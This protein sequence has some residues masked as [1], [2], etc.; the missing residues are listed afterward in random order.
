MTGTT[1][2]LGDCADP[3][4]QEVPRTPVNGR[5]RDPFQVGVDALRD[6]LLGVTVPIRR[7][8]LSTDDM[9][10]EQWDKDACQDEPTTEGGDLVNIPVL[11]RVSTDDLRR[12]FRATGCDLKEAAVRI[13]ESAAWRGVTFP[14][15]TR[16]CRV[17]LQSG[18]FFQQ[19]RDVDG[20]PVF[21]FQNMLMGPWR[22][23]LNASVA[24]ILH[25]LESSILQLSEQD[26]DVRCTV[27]ALVGKPF[28]RISKKKKR[29]KD[30]SSVATE[31][32]DADED[33]EGEQSTEEPSV[34]SH[35][36]DQNTW[37]PL[38]MGTNP[39]VYPEE[40]F[41]VH[42]DIL[43]FQRLA[44]LLPAHY[45]ERLKRLILVPGQGRSMTYMNTTFTMRKFITSSRTRNKVIHLNRASELPKYV[46]DEELAT[47][48]GGCVEV[49]EENAFEC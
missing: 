6:I 26:P 44:E 30:E 13:V 37:N 16:K 14:I 17:E 47:L 4:S 43:M 18:Q 49:I 22:G 24:A 3:Q 38:R 41:H 11:S 28:K 10:T 12:F 42:S 25:R 29:R 27:I 21:Y 20:D 1:R 32:K 48:A 33:G 45:P 15:D 5:G 36:V 46:E 34:A 19:G 40:D 23:N 35:T 8:N 2:T 39:R 31:S 7:E 9:S